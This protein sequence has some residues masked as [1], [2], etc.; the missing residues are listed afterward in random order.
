MNRLGAIAKFIA[1]NESVSNNEIAEK[2]HLSMPT[3]LQ[4]TR[5]LK[6]RGVIAETGK[7]DSTGGRKEKTRFY[8]C[9]AVK[10]GGRYDHLCRRNTCRYDR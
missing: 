7:Y 10:E 3:V 2:L 6:E 5:V 8:C 1:D 4:Y 9:A